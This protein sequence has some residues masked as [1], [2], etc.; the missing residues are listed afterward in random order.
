[1]ANKIPAIL[2]TLTLFVLD[3]TPI[4]AGVLYRTDFEAGS[5]AGLSA[6][7]N[8]AQV[9]ASVTYGAYGTIDTY[10]GTTSSKGVALTVN[11][12]GAS[13]PWTAGLNSGFLNV[14]N[15]ITNLGLLTLSFS[16]S[17]SQTHPVIVSLVSSNS[18]GATGSLQTLIYPATTNYLQRFAIDLS[19]MTPSGTGAFD[20]TSPQ[21]CISF[22]LDSAAGGDGWPDA[23]GVGL[24]LDNV[25]YSTPAYYVKT[26]GSDSAAGTNEATAFLTPAHAVNVAVHAGDIVVVMGGNYQG[27]QSTCYYG[28][29]GAPDAWL[30]LK[31]YPGQVPVLADINMGGAASYIEMRGLDVLGF[32]G[33]DVNGDRYLTPP[34]TY[35]K[36]NANAAGI[37]V[38]GTQSSTV[39]H[40]FRFANNIAEYNAGSGI[41]L[42]RVDRV[43][44]ENNTV[45]YNCWWT[46]WGNSGINSY[47]AIDFETNSTYRTVFQGN[48][49]YGNEC[50][51]PC[52]DTQPYAWSDG[53]GIILDTS[54]SYQGRALVQNNLCY[55]NGGSGIHAYN[56]SNADIF[57]NT[58]Y[59][60][61]ASPELQTGQIFAYSAD[62]VNIFN[63]IIVAPANI[64]G[65]SGFNEPITLDIN[66]TNV[67]FTNNLCYGGQVALPVDNTNGNTF[68]NNVVADPRFISPLIDAASASFRLNSGSPGLGAA[69]ASGAR[70][71]LDLA[72]APRPAG[73]ADQ[74]AYQ[75]QPNTCFPPTFSP[76]PGNS[77]TAANV[78]MTSATTGF[79]IVYTTN[80]TIPVVA[81]G[82]IANGTAYTGP[83]AVSSNTT[84][85]AIAWKSGLTNSA[86]TSGRYTFNNLAAVPIPNLQ[87][88]PGVVSA[89]GV[90]MGVVCRTPGA[91]VRYT[92]D[93]SL[94]SPTHG[95]IAAQALPLL[96]RGGMLQA[97]AYTPGRAN[98]A[99]A[100]V[101]GYSIYSTTTPGSGTVT[102]SASVEVGSRFVSATNALVTALRVWCPR[103]GPSS[104]TARLRQ[105]WGSGSTLA[106]VNISTTVNAWS[107]G[108][109]SPPVSI[110]AD[111]NY[112][113]CYTAPANYP[114][115]AVADGLSTSI[116][117]GPLCF[118]AG[119]NG[120]YA[121]TAGSYPTLDGR[122][123][124]YGADVFLYISPPQTVT[125]NLALGSSANPSIY[126]GNLTFTAAVQTN[127]V[128]AGN[129]AGTIVFLD[130]A[131][132]LSTNVLSGGVATF[133]ITRLNAG[134]HNISATYS[135]CAPANLAQT[136]NPLPVILAG[137]YNGSTNLSASNLSVANNLD[138][139]NLTLNGIALLVGK[140]AG[141]QELVSGLSST[142][143]QTL[144]MSTANS[145]Y[146]NLAGALPGTPVNGNT[147]IAVV[148]CSS[149]GGL[150]VT[151][152]AQT[153]ANWTR[154]VGS[155]NSGG[156]SSEI[157]YATNVFNADTNL[158]INIA[159]YFRIA[160][161]VME[162]AGGLT[163]DQVCTNEGYGT[164]ADTGATE[165]TSQ[166]NEVLV[167]GIGFMNSSYG[168]G[169]F[170]NGFGCVADTNSTS[171][172]AAENIEIYALTNLVNAAGTADSGGTLSGT[173]DWTGVV[174]TF[175]SQAGSTLSLGG[176]AAGNYTLAGV[177]SVALTALPVVLAGTRPYDGTTNAGAP[178]LQVAN[179]IGADNVTVASGT[180]G[181]AGR[182]PGVEAINSFGTLALG[183]NMAGDYTLVGASGSVTITSTAPV[184]GAVTCANGQITMMVTGTPGAN[185]VMQATTNLN[186]A[187]W[188]SLTTNTAPFFYTETNIGSLR[189]RY[190][191]SGI[192][193]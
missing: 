78:S 97:I 125:T 72:G 83:V 185:Y 49:C 151:N 67:H 10:M 87:F 93:G 4:L 190:F 90:T 52:V 168:L 40:D 166:D 38:N 69:A 158:S 74:G 5:W 180:G 114:F 110:I 128:I 3:G 28:T 172:A 177:N 48:Q 140:D 17:A 11:S 139:T 94:P 167:G 33:V 149:G 127:G 31:N 141:A 101:S 95:T 123:T 184:F 66:D 65:S 56:F 132:P 147:L 193:Q 71:D 131:V 178:M 23:S 161:V 174:A 27:N 111:S 142:L 160:A 30:V 25:N 62:S 129:A 106:T 19:T 32:S 20:P 136:V 156:G 175:K 107:T 187:T 109:V 135:N 105:G 137:T 8:N 96:G 102:P 43:M 89:S 92:L 116:T 37:T 183:N 122:G 80:G 152:I 192:A 150:R 41:A 24:R 60:N 170:R 143:I 76:L 54:L 16:L 188:V 55:N 34:F 173:A 2:L 42:Q 75:S 47:N 115:A 61:S 191:R 124:N 144:A 162:Y 51:A 15:S 59:C 164:V 155:L 165:G 84:F 79:S 6:F 13:G 100:T 9:T 138:G 181:L 98:S 163:L 120:V 86:L 68:A 148:G 130:G 12:T 77:L 91:L 117:N 46:G 50:M 21:I 134:H 1:M 14:T 112:V 179:R 159:N 186:P 121:T 29:A 39:A 36:N 7:S 73:V 45:R 18:A 104:Y 58:A 22:A 85:N 154:A 63:N 57:Q 26:N 64:T 103:G 126:G 113:V 145:T 99:V 133:S 146:L 108:L 44:V 153:G 35:S 182:G 171:G 118:P 53:N 70:S 119:N 157:W 176:A 81:N 169:N 88:V 82:V 189:Q